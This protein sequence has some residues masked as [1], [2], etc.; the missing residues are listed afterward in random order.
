MIETLY[1]LADIHIPENRERYEEYKQVFANLYKMLD[2]DITKKMIVICGDFLDNKIVGAETLEIGKDFMNELSKRGEI[3]IFPGNHD[4]NTKN[5]DKKP[6]IEPMLRHTNFGDKVHYI[7]NDGVYKINNINFGLTTITAKK[8]TQIENKNPDELYIGLYHGQM[9]KSKS[10]CDYEF[11][12]EHLFKTSDFKDYDIV[13][14]GDIHKFQYLNK[15]KTIAYSSSLIQQNFGETINNHG[16]IKWNLNTKKGEFFQVPNDYVFKTFHIENMNDYTIPDIENKKTRLKLY[17]NHSKK[18]DIKKYIKNIREKYNIISYEYYDIF[19]EQ[20]IVV[21]EGKIVNKN[22]TDIYKDYIQTNKIKEDKEVT[23]FINNYLQ[24]TNEEADKVIKNLKLKRLEFGNLFTYGSNNIVN[25]ESINGVNIIMGRN[26]LGKSSLIDVILLTIYNTYSKYDTS[27]EAVNRRHKKGYSILTLEVNNDLYEIKRTFERVTNKDEKEKIN[28]E[29]SVKKNGININN[30]NKKTTDNDL[31]SYFGSYN[32]MVMSSIILQFGINFAN[33]KIKEQNELLISIMGLSVYENLNKHCEA[34][35]IGL[36]SIKIPKLRKLLT[37]KDY[38]EL[39]QGTIEQEEYLEEC[40]KSVEGE[41]DSIMEEMNNIKKNID[42]EIIKMDK[43]QLQKKEQELNETII[44]NEQTINSY[45]YSL[46]NLDDLNELSQNIINENE[47]YNKKIKLEYSNIKTINKV[48]P[49]NELNYNKL[50]T[51]L[52]DIQTKINVLKEKLK[53]VK[54]IDTIDQ[55]VKK[56][57]NKLFEINNLEKQRENDKKLLKLLEEKNIHLLNHKFDDLCAKCN[58]NKE[59]HS[60]IG[61]IIEINKLK[62]KISKYIITDEIECITEINKL[63]EIKENKNKIKLFELSRE[64]ILQKI[65]TEENKINLLKEN[66]IINENN[67]KIKIT[68]SQYERLLEK[69]KSIYKNIS[70]SIKLNSSNEKIKLEINKIQ[71]I[72]QKQEDYKEEIYRLQELKKDKIEVEQRQQQFKKEYSNI[73]VSLYQIKKE[74]EE[75]LKIIEEKEKYEKEVIIHEKI[76]NLFL[77]GFREYIFSS[78]MNMLEKRIN[79]VLRKMANYEI[80]IEN[81]DKQYVFRKIIEDKDNKAIQ[82]LKISELCGYERV[83]FNIAIRLALNSMSVLNK[84]N[85][86]IIDEGFSA[87]DEQNINNVTHLFE[88]IKKEYDFCL[89]ISHL[90]EIKNLN[91][92]K[93]N[94]EYNENT[95]DSRIYV[96]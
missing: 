46:M 87:A 16:F 8:V 27:C 65:F 80:V 40:L 17:Y 24:K 69:N 61:Y 43:I 23:E 62:D 11:K 90:S 7:K 60:K 78:R 1:H 9:Y 18:E 63:K 58:H 55:Q 2:N 85:F 70:D 86:L 42:E 66:E 71:N 74:K 48:N 76:I 10:D 34:E 30:I 4:Q 39:I 33:M 21:K 32:D 31:K 50:K 72:M 59:I 94:I 83:S 3:I 54:D 38:E 68:I 13:M 45:G 47:D 22:I 12:D 14:L 56:L 73:R 57:E 5:M 77:T 37:N 6:F 52:N 35:K 79:N 64:T 88:V 75:Q 51:E 82:T 84:N 67:E 89:I 26:G 92:K 53:E 41:R 49:F 91:E 20:Q 28:S 25:F 36:A 19:E 44:K 93:I 15:D 29:L 81:K 95:K 96:E